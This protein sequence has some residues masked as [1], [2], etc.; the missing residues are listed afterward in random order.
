MIA[1]LK[2]KQKIY[3]KKLKWF[4]KSDQAGGAEI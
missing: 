3:L 2:N 1:N 4:R